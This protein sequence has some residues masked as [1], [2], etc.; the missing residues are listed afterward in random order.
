M[1]RI[2]QIPYSMIKSI[3]VGPDPDSKVFGVLMLSIFSAWCV[4]G[5]CTILSKPYTTP[6]KPDQTINLKIK[7]E[8]GSLV[9][10]TKENPGEPKYGIIGHTDHGKKY[11]IEF[12]DGSK[13]VSVLEKL[14]EPGDKI[15]INDSELGYSHTHIGKD[16]TGRVCGRHVDLTEKAQNKF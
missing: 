13:P 1:L 16:G 5:T 14:I 7:E 10:E 3:V 12:F 4:V 6:S 9:E 8:F 15:A 2:R 11:I